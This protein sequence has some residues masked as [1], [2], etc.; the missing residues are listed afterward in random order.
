[1]AEHTTEHGVFIEVYGIG[2]LLTRGAAIGKSELALEL[3]SRGHSLIVG[4]APEFTCIAPDI[5]NGTCPVVLSDFLEVEGL[6]IIN[7]RAM[8]DDAAT[9]QHKYLQLII[10]LKQMSSQELKK[11]DRLRSS[12]ATRLL[13]G[14]E[15]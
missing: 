11:I 13:L 9:K 2:V 12:H 10:N 5:I 4:N 8:F 7:I 1:M 14:L 6:G 15:R 3:I